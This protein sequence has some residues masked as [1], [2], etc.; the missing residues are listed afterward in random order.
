MM[1]IMR[2]IREKKGVISISFSPTKWIDKNTSR[3]RLSQLAN[4]S[5]MKNHTPKRPYRFNACNRRTYIVSVVLD[6]IHLWAEQSYSLS[7]AIFELN[8]ILNSWGRFTTSLAE[9]CC[10]CACISRQI[11]RQIPWVIVSIMPHACSQILWLVV[12]YICLAETHLGWS[13]TC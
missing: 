8:L 4:E 3:K 6:L 5:K 11:V 7:S 1:L 10:R 2:I 13:D 9:A 12:L